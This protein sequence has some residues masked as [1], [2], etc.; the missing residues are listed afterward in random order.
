MRPFQKRLCEK[1]LI[2]IGPPEPWCRP[3]AA[4]WLS[5]A[6]GNQ[7]AFYHSDSDCMYAELR[8]SG[9][10]AFFLNIIDFITTRTHWTLPFRRSP[11]I[12]ELQIDAVRAVTA[13]R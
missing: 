12:A 7:S 13:R 5:S 6:T 4:C 1:T 3:C 8:T 2:G 10:S 11:L 9:C